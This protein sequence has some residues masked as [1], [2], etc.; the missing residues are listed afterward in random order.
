MKKQVAILHQGFIPVYRAK[1]YEIL[2][3][4]SATTYVV[5]HGAP[6]SNTGHRELQGVPDFPNV[7]V[8]NFEFSVLGKRI[9]Y[10]PVIK[11]ILLGSIDA[12]V[13]G[14]EIRFI[15]NLVLFALCKVIRV[16]VIWWGQGF[17]KNELRGFASRLLAKPTALVKTFLARLGDK[18]IVY[19][20][21]GLAKLIRA[22]VLRD[23]VAVVR[24]TIDIEEQHELHTELIKVDPVEL[25]KKLH[26]RLESKVLLYVGR[27]YKEKNVEQFLHLIDRLN[28]RK[29]CGSFVEGLIIGDGP[30]LDRLQKIGRDMEGIHFVGELY[31]QRAVAEYMRISSAVVIPGKVGL[32]VNHAFSQGVPVITRQHD[33]HAPE[34]EY[35]VHGENGLVIDGDF[36]S[37]VDATVNYLNS[38]ELVKKLAHGA[39]LIRNKLTL[40]F[41][42][43]AFDDAVTKTIAHA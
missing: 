30:D 28:A 22:G 35:I 36:D 14:H 8:K 31:D 12:V 38:P 21:S 29:L 4:N 25:R 43:S 9:I 2:N 17:E 20:E 5:Y 32:A 7:R 39:L 33:Y 13:L 10:Q 18:Y 26:V 16:P 37:F 15:S 23:N 19:T 34:V 40:E 11:R 41:M 24:N 6:P 27:I 42:V 1:F 3:K